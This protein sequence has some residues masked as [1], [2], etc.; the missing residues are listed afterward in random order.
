MSQARETK[1]KVNKRD[2]IKLNSF[3]T[4]KETINKTK[5]PPTEWDKIFT[6]D[7]FDKGLLS[8]LYKEFIQSNIKKQTTRLKNG[9]RI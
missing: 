9:Q 5:R 4:V 2:Y 3:C 6:S 8:K 7:I 1:A